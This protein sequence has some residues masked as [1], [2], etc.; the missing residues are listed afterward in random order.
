[1]TR[2]GYTLT[3]L[4]GASLVAACTG[5]IEGTTDTETPPP[6]TTTGSDGNTFDHDN[7]TIS[8]WDLIDRLTKEGPPSFS[9]Q[10]HGCTKIKYAT[11]GNV[12]RSVGINTGNATVPSAGQLYTSGGPAMGSPNYGARVRENLS[13]TTSGASREFDIFASGAL[14]IITAVPMLARCN[15]GGIAA[16]LFDAN[17]QCQMSGLTCIMGLQ[18]T[19]AH[20]ELCNLTVSKASTP[21]IGKRLAVAAVMAAAYTCE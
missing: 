3:I 12:L 13:V 10:M 14:E 4:F 6:G 17:N 20:V 18:A 15:V 8:V 5:D 1:M 21:D 11:L 9:S 19:D 2:F 7:S 16:T